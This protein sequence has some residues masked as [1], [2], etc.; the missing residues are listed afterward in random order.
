MVFVDV[1]MPDLDRF[2]MIDQIDGTRLPLFVFVK[3]YGE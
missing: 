2:G 3:G 1:P